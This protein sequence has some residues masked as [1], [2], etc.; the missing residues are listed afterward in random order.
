[1]LYLI[2]FDNLLGEKCCPVVLICVSW[3][4]REVEYLLAIYI[5]FVILCV[6]VGNTIVILMGMS[7]AF[8]S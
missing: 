2:F 5:S 1:M 7:L 8:H 3:M 4:T 6:V